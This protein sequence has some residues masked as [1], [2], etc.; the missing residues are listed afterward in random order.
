ME[1]RRRETINEGINELAKIVPGCEKNKGSILQ[2][3]VSFI[4]ELK[5]NEAQH[6]ERW[7][8]E[9]LVTEQALREL[10]A[11]NDELKRECERAYKEL[12]SIRQIAEEAG[13]KLPPRK[14]Q[15]SSTS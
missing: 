6:L 2:R 9:K 7:T 12:N 5:T 10:S 8:F 14:A 11:S 3:T 13:V 4:Q 1:R 15:P